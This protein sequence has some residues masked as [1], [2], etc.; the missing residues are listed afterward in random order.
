[1]GGLIS[2]R[3]LLGVNSNLFFLVSFPFHIDILKVVIDKI[4]VSDSEP[5]PRNR[6]L[7][8]R[9]KKVSTSIPTHLQ[10]I[11]QIQTPDIP[12]NRCQ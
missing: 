10:C 9:K 12:F 4:L 1:M 7:K 5:D 3:T 11:N 8:R 2:T 6:G